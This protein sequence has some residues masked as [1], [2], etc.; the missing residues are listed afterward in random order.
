MQQSTNIVCNGLAS[1]KQ[2]FYLFITINMT[3]IA[4]SFDDGGQKRRNVDKTMG[5][6]QRAV[7]IQ[8]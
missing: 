6:A 2:D 4:L 3:T 5:T 7:Q 8:C 1:L